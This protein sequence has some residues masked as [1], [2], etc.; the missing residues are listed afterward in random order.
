M[1]ACR[2]LLFRVLSVVV[3]FGAL[4]AIAA[5]ESRVAAGAENPAASVE[6]LS[7]SP[8]PAAVES[9]VPGGGSAGTE[10]PAPTRKQELVE[11]RTA[12]TETWENTDGSRTVSVSSV[13]KYF[14]RPGSSAWEPIDT[15]LI[16][17]PQAAGRAGSAGRVEN[18]PWVR[19]AANQ[20]TLWFGPSGVGAGMQQLDVGGSTVGFSP[21]DAAGGV[22]PKVEG[23]TASY[24][25]LWSDTDVVYRSSATGADERLVLRSARAPD[26][27][28]FDVVGATPRLRGDGGVDLVV[29]DRVVAQI[30]A[31]TVETA[32]GWVDP[33]RAGVVYSLEPVPAPEAAA[34]PAPPAPADTTPDATAGPTAPAEPD[35]P[36]TSVQESPVPDAST[37]TSAPA[38]PTTTTPSAEPGSASGG[39]ST[40][41]VQSDQPASPD[42]PRLRV[43]VSVSREW[44]SGLADSAFPVVIDPTVTVTGQTA[45]TSKSYAND[46]STWQ[47]AALAGTDS[48]DRAWRGLAY[49]PVPWPTGSGQ[50]WY[51]NSASLSVARYGG[52]NCEACTLSAKGF[53]SDPGAFNSFSLGQG[54]L[55][56][57][58]TGTE[59]YPV[60]HF[61]ATGYI[62]AHPGAGVWFGFVGDEDVSHDVLHYLSW[63]GSNT[64][65]VDYIFFQSSPPTQLLS[66]SGT[67]S[68]TTPLL[69]AQVVEP[70]DPDSAWETVYYDFK[71]STAADG[72]GVVVDSGWVDSS[73]W[74]VPAGVLSDGGVYYVK[75]W[76][77]IGTPW[78]PGAYGY[79]PAAAPTVTTT[80]TVKARLGG[81]GPAPTDTVGAVPGS[82][83]TPAEGS[84]SSGISPASVTVNMVTGNLSA[85][86][87]TKSLSALGGSAG[88]GLV[89]DSQGSTVLDGGATGL[90][91]KY[92][93]D[94]QPIG[95]R[96]DPSVNFN[97][98]GSPMGGNT[99]NAQLGAE[100]N[101][102]IRFPASGSWRLGGWVASGGTM[103]VYL[104]G[105]TTAY[106][107][108]NGGGTT[109]SFPSTGSLAANSQH[110][111]RVVYAS[112]AGAAKTGQL[113]AYDTSVDE[114]LPAK[115]VMVPGG[116]LRPQATGL[117]AGWRM[118]VNPQAGGWSRLD[119][120]GTQVIVRSTNGDTA[121][122]Q[123]LTDGTY[124]PPTGSSALLSTR[125]TSSGSGIASGTAE[126]FELNSGGYM[127]TFATDGWVQSVKSIQDNLHPTALQYTYTA[128]SATT[129]PVLDR[130]TDPV[131]G[132]YAQFCYGQPCTGGISGWNV[133]DGMLAKIDHWD[134]TTTQ[135]WYST[136]NSQLAR[137]ISPGNLQADFAY[138]A[139]P[140]PKLMSL[141]D[142]LAN[143]AKSAG[144]RS[145]CTSDPTKCQYSLTYDSTGRIASVTQPAPTAGAIR[146]SR[147]Y[148]WSDV[149]N[150]HS[151]VKLN[152]DTLMSPTLNSQVWWDQQSRVIEQRDP[153]GRSTLTKWDPNI[154][155]PLATVAPT[156]LQT[157][158]RY[159]PF[160]QTLTD[161]YGPAPTGCFDTNAPFLP[162]SC[163][164]TVPHTQHVFDEGY[165]GLR[166]TF[167]SNPYFAGT[168]ATNTDGFGG[169]QG[170]SG[171]P[172]QCPT[173]TRVLTCV[174]WP[175]LPVTPNGGSI[176]AT[177]NAFT[178]SARFEGSISN[179][180]P[181]VIN[182]ETAQHATVY[183][184]G[185]LYDEIDARTAN[186]PY[187]HTYGT[188]PAAWAAPGLT[189]IP[190][191]DHLIRIDYLG[192]STSANGLWIDWAPNLLTSRTCASG[193]ST[194]GMLA[195]WKGDGN[196]GAELG[197]DLTG[198]TSYATGK[199]GQGFNLNYTPLTAPDFPIITNGMTFEAWLKPQ[200]SSGSFGY[201]MQRWGAGST[202]AYK[203]LMWN[204]KADWVVNDFSTR[205]EEWSE[206][207]A[208]ELYDGGLHHIAVSWDGAYERIY[209]DGQ[210]R[211]THLYPIASPNLDPAT[212]L[213]TVLGPSYVGIIDEPTFYNRALTD[214]QVTAI[215]NAGT[216]GKCANPP[217]VAAT[218]KPMYGLETRTVDPDG[219][220]T[221]T[222]YT[223]PNPAHQIGPQYGLPVTVTQDP[224]GL[225][226]T[227]TTTYETPSATT[228]LRPV[229]KTLPEGNTTD[230]RHY[231]GTSSSCGS[232]Q[233]NG[234][235]A[236][237]CGIT[238]G[239]AQYGLLAEK[240][241]PAQTAGGPRRVQ[242]FLYDSAG[243]TVGRRVNLAADIATTAWQCTT[244]DTLG[245]TTQ[246]SWP[247]FNG[248]AARTATYTYNPATPLVASVADPTG[249]ITSEIDILGRQ[250]SYTDATGWRSEYTYDSYGRLT[251]TRTGLTTANHTTTTNTYNGTTGELSQVD[252]TIGSTTYT[253]HL[254][255]QTDGRVAA[256]DYAPGTAKRVDYTDDANGHATGLVYSNDSTT[257]YTDAATYTPAGRRQ[258]ALIQTTTGL[259][260][261]HSG[262]DFTYD[263]AGRL[264]TAYLAGKQLD[265]S[266]ANNPSCTVT[267]AGANTNRTSITSTIDG[268][269][270]T[271][272]YCYNGA[273]QLISASDTTTGTLT[274]DNHGNQT[275]DGTINY[276]WDS[277]DR[278]TTAQTAGA[279]NT[280]TYT[281]DTLDRLLTRTE[282]AVTRRYTYAGRTDTPAALLATNNTVIEDYINLPGG[283]LITIPNTGTATWSYPNLQGHHSITTDSNGGVQSGPVTYDP[284]GTPYGA[285]G[286]IN[287]TA[288]NA[289][290]GA[291]GQAGKLQEYGARSVVAMG[292][293]PY[294]DTRGR[295][296]S[297]DP[298]EGGCA[299]P[300]TYVFGDPINSSDTNGRNACQEFYGMHMNLIDFISGLSTVAMALNPPTTL[301]LIVK[302]I[303]E[304][305][306][307]DQVGEATGHPG[308]GSGGR[309][310]SLER[311][312]SHM[313]GRGPLGAKD[314]EVL[315][316]AYALGLFTPGTT[317]Y[318]V[319]QTQFYL[320]CYTAGLPYPGH[321]R[322]G[323]YG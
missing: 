140:T 152:G 75:V 268:T 182:L 311:S 194:N 225:N 266:Y 16:A 114:E 22:A 19:S 267:N 63:P 87:G 109:A 123:R 250:V 149:A 236:S 314:K 58:T 300:Y 100:W 121:T 262:N 81:G 216:A 11:L 35:T 309:R 291:F 103:T 297:V 28:A 37:T 172:L 42:A 116:W 138:N 281:R 4:A 54:L 184:D 191:G 230:Y 175:T 134:G 288:T 24:G 245:R 131:S 139:D 248:A 105:S 284:W 304:T 161:E 249:T 50:P 73:T 190:A 45:T 127:F 13:P 10:V 162:V 227:T 133:P 67:I 277:A 30:P 264:T 55:G 157:T 168:P 246:Q 210:L 253:G 189:V 206:A 247:A 295:F 79:F 85:S 260:D 293:R 257:F 176:P 153:A 306:V 49:V 218:L 307:L 164:A 122:F 205:S 312:I 76:D 77:N 44:L 208:P 147:T 187:T 173:G 6:D 118:S 167:W 255:Y 12:T 163:T 251:Q 65:T 106:Y 102:T 282:S 319:G 101:G 143:A 278:L 271:T 198:T 150:R 137:I 217:A 316:E 90:Y 38:A 66:P 93:S 61:D 166:G 301:V 99:A 5:T 196:A 39:E 272:S 95:Q 69:S 298:I 174:V 317:A 213:Q 265:I 243:R 80:L 263:G 170:T 57:G 228:W 318:L 71:V 117:P 21:V 181:F 199:V 20:F 70:A 294:S 119:D 258:S 308:L 212:A 270:T 256:V 108:V 86:V 286:S 279:G 120:L 171:D 107:T 29:A 129:A 148:D 132:R 183:I 32:E 25:G 202:G 46:G 72:T 111:I 74:Q 274:Y 104:D 48:L 273:D 160:T 200:M 52:P 141:T 296:L 323:Q 40:S 158:K 224:G 82:T 144:N 96:V 2:G 195:W 226:L 33:A 292:A 238:A 135:L 110:T 285:G 305:V 89:Y 47:S 242:Q 36:D 207:S 7:V 234:A 239:A 18:G 113:W 237:A 56:Q 287:N 275:T 51:L 115:N 276:T 126:G 8:E 289:D 31:P 124:K 68:S 254:T 9:V 235:I 299:N 302:A 53:T 320:S 188:W 290:V 244:Y 178:W 259:I 229:S 94:G 23:D 112:P 321:D 159:D 220:T 15:T 252:T 204:N 185:N 3:V 154:D 261:P 232:G 240:S 64:I 179:P 41:T 155:R 241:E 78:A 14:Q 197:A 280:I 130:I 17:D 269:P 27:F 60:F 231:C 83:P 84:P 145:D 59:Q 125:H 165:T 223:D 169:T 303:A 1:R 146:P 136:T 180:A 209:I 34:P 310:S 43:R 97:W 322:A 62:A 128:L 151:T 222:G 88:V 221:T 98:S 142:P 313:V 92:S 211:I 201:I 186:N 91:A 203:L 215:Y 26:S 283:I 219:K 193:V 233:Q 315:G 156:G 177:G 192:S 214:A